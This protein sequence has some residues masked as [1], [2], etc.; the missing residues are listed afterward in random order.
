MYQ[1]LDRNLSDRLTLQADRPDATGAAIR[2]EHG[3]HR[4][5]ATWSAAA[6]PG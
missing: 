6:R 5:M 2:E 1:A 4:V 3:R